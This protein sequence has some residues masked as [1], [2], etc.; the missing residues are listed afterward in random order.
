MA[1]VID[2]TNPLARAIVCLESPHTT[3]ADVMLYV[4]AAFIMYEDVFASIRQDVN[5]NME[6]LKPPIEEIGQILIRRTGELINSKNGHDAYFTA[7]FMHPG[8][9]VCTLS[10]RSRTY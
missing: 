2:F 6:G 4:S 3:P 10:I 9:L 7:T 1:Q 5:S 8:E